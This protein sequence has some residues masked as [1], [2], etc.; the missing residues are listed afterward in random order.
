VSE[1]QGLRILFEDGSRIVYRLSGTGTSGATLR[2]YVESFEGDA[3][4]HGLDAQVALAE[5]IGAALRI[6]ELREHTGRGAPT[7]IT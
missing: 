2:L 4:K 7:V 1:H 3:A 6:S 5:L